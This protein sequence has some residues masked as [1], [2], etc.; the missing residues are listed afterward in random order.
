MPFFSCFSPV[1]RLSRIPVLRDREKSPDLDRKSSYTSIYMMSHVSLS[2][3][4]DVLIAANRSVS[5]CG[6]AI[7]PYV[8]QQIP[9]YQFVNKYRWSFLLPSVLH[10]FRPLRCPISSVFICSDSHE[11]QVFTHNERLRR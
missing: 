7:R 6:G 3:V 1:D 10:R 5:Y 2:H 9:R 4:A 11:P 8:A